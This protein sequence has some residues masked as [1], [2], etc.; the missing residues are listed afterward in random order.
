M[1]CNKSFPGYPSCYLPAG[2]SN[3]HKHVDG[4]CPARYLVSGNNQTI[5]YLHCERL[6]GHDGSHYARMITT[7]LKIW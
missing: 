3:D 1:Q 2:H 6:Y 7:E 4:K 5:I